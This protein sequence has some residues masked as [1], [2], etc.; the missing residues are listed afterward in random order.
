MCAKDMHT[1]KPSVAQTRS[2]PSRYRIIDIAIATASLGSRNLTGI[3]H[4]AR[5]SYVVAMVS[6]GDDNLNILD[7]GPRSVIIPWH[8]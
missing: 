7:R 2:A 4:V 1:Q 3:R 8:G 5:I 6:G